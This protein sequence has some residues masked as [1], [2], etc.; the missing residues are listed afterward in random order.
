MTEDVALDVGTIHTTADGD[1]CL[2]LIQKPS[3]MMLYDAV[4]GVVEAFK[5]I[6]HRVIMNKVHI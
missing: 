4:C 2:V 6:R 3:Q 1:Y 5:I